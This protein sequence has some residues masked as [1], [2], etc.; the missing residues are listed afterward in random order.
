M[1]LSWHTR[2]NHE[3]LLLLFT[4]WG[5]DDS[6]FTTLNVGH[7]DCLIVWDYTIPEYDDWNF[8]AHYRSITLLAWSFGVFVASRCLPKLPPLTR[9]IAVNGTLRPI[10]DR[11]GIPTAVF[12][13]TLEHYNDANRRKFEKRAA[14]KM[15]DKLSPSIAFSRRDT[16]S[17]LQELRAFE[18]MVKDRGGDAE[19]DR[20]YWTLALLSESDRI[21][22][23]QNMRRFWREKGQAIPGDHLPDFQK[24]L[25]DYCFST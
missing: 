10:D 18:I 19:A 4:G 6:L 12:K 24:I 2:R 7:R 5:G 16:S 20:E 11:F 13:A 8:L 23:V 21:F 22:P 1:K 25:D 15:Y 9:A 17:Q 3:E 14:G